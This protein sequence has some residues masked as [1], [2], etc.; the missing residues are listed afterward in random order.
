MDTSD[1][2]SQIL[3]EAGT[4]ELEILVFRVEN[5]TYGINVAKVR[6]VIRPPELLRPPERHPHVLGVFDL[7]GIVV[8]AVNVR[9]WLGLPQQDIR[10][11][12]RVIVTEFNDVW[13]GFW[14]DGVDRIYR[15]S[16]EQIEPPPKGLGDSG[17]V[18]S[19]AHIN[20]QLV[21]ML[22]FE[23][24]VQEI[25]PSEKLV[26]PQF[27]RET[28]FDR[29]QCNILIA[30]DSHMMRSML[31]QT[32][33]SAGY[34]ELYCC[35]NGQEA[36][37]F[38]KKTLAEIGEGEPVKSRINA[39][40]TDIEMPQMDGLHFTKLIKE[41]AR[42]MDLPVVIFSSIISDENRRKGQSVGANAQITKPEI[43]ELVNIVDRLVQG[44][45]VEAP[46]GISAEG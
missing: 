6:E 42:L 27:D 21:P 16:W 28:V 44:L 8:P 37:E 18:T 13:F 40:I 39:V 15:V 14:V 9:I 38:L 29:S 7:R 35:N 41:H 33:Q 3:M 36:W 20:D 31:T 45:K 46:S 19:M 43:G 4:N 22:D 34:G 25:S 10:A 11:S 26:S 32:L 24:V 17:Y 5:E 23:K 1:I 2:R 30:E 12:D